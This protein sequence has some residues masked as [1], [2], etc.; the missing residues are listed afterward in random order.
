MK[1]LLSLT[2]SKLVEN[3]FSDECILACGSVFKQ[4]FIEQGFT[5]VLSNEFAID[6]LKIIITTLSKIKYELL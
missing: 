3:N 2:A 4:A 1:E 5:R 6:S